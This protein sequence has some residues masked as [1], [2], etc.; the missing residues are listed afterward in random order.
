MESIIRVPAWAYDFCYY[1]LAMAALVV[2]ATLY[3]VVLLLLAPGL[4]FMKKFFPILTLLS[5]GLVTVVL[6]MMN[7]WVCRSA[8]APNK[9][10]ETFRDRPSAPGGRFGSETFAVMCANDKDCQAA[11]TDTS[12]SCT[13]GGRGV[14]GGC[15]YA[16]TQGASGGDYPG[17]SPDAF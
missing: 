1:N 11:S 10:K 12:K 15:M 13:C 14:C 9:N 16:K 8:L 7:F 2:V 17:F 4:S 3:S 5:S 6:T